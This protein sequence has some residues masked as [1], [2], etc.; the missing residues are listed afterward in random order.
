MPL[1]KIIKKVK[2]MSFEAERG[3]G[4]RHIHGIYMVCDGFQIACDRLKLELDTCKICGQKPEFSRGI[5]RFNPFKLFGEHE[6]CECDGGKNCPLCFPK[7]DGI[8]FLM[9]VGKQYTEESFIAEA[10][11]MG[12]SKKIPWIPRDFIVGESWI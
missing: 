3:C 4:F 11:N 2:T 5:T 10:L 7:E 6:N 12:V 8:D 9:W 1:L